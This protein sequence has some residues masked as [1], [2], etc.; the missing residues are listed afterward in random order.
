VIFCTI[1][2]SWVTNMRLA[3]TRVSL[4]RR[5]STVPATVEGPLWT[6]RLV[7]SKGESFTDLA[8]QMTH[9]GRLQRAVA[10]RHL[11][12]VTDPRAEVLLMRALRD[13]SM[14][15]RI[16]AMQALIERDPSRPARP[17]V[18]AARGVEVG[19]EGAYH[20]P[21][22]G[23][24]LDLGLMALPSA[25]ATDTFTHGLSSQ[26]WNVRV[27]SASALAM[28]EDPRAA[29]ALICALDDP[30]QVVR[31]FAIKGLRRRGTPDAIEP[32]RERAR[33]EGPRGRRR[34]QA[35]IRAIS[36]RDRR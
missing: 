24:I 31:N 25:R 17:L 5:R 13:P 26:D 19:R 12:R 1:F 6:Q 33:R 32:L 35:A 7:K 29:A 21:S 27:Q 36:K 11:T 15:V 18:K 28:S 14:P 23:E 16:S 20:P 34:V 8:R 4:Q 9:G 3:V 22:V 2:L 30:D 10:V